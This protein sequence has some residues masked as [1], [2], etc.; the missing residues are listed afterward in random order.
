MRDLLFKNL[1]SGDRKRRIIASSEIMDR[2]GVHSVIHRHVI[3]LVK[4]VR[5]A[6]IARPLPS[7]YLLKER[8]TQEQEERFLC[9]IK[10]SAYAVYN[11]KVYLLLFAHSLH[12]QL[13]FAGIAEKQREGPI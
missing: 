8:N 2:G 1:T 9:R 13:N 10:G 4:E 7:V 6:T 11:G 5:C 3:C 12:I